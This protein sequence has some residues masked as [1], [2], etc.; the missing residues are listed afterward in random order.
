M[1]S[2]TAAHFRTMSEA[3]TRTKKVRA[4]ES[5]IDQA[6]QF[7]KRIR[8]AEIRVEHKISARESSTALPLSSHSVL[9]TVLPDTV[10]VSSSEAPATSSYGVL[11][12][13]DVTTPAAHHTTT[14]VF[15]TSTTTIT[16][17]TVTPVTHHAV[18]EPSN[19]K[20]KLPKLEPK[21]FNGDLTKWETFWNSFK[22]SIHS[23]PALTTIH[24]FQ[25]L[26]SLLKG[27]AF[28]DVAGLKLTELNY[29]EAIDTLTKRFGN[30]QLIIS[31]HM[32]TLLELEPVVSPTNIKV[33]RCLYDKI[34]FQ[35]HSLKSLGVPLDP[36]SNLLSSLFMSRL[37]QEF[38]LII[39]RE[40]VK[41]E[42]TVDQI[43]Q[44]VEREIG[45]REHAF[46]QTGSHAHGTSA[47]LPTATAMMGGDGKP[48]CC[49]CRQNHPSVSCKTVTD[50]AQ[51]IAIL[52]KSGR[53]FVCLKRHHL[54]RDCKSSISCY[55]CNGRH[56]A[57]VCK[58]HDSSSQS[59]GD[60]AN[61][62][63]Q[64]HTSNNFMIQPPVSSGHTTTTTA[65]F[66][67]INGDIPV[68]LQTVQAYIHKP[69][70]SA[71]GMT[72]RLMFDGGSQRLYIT[73]RVKEALR[74]ETECKEVVN[75]KNIWLRDFQ[76]SYCRCCHCFDTPQGGKSD[77]HFVLDCATNM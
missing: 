37:S 22:S 1:D 69:T 59:A 27:S 51:R 21:K 20:V 46:T 73:E 24:K 17:A 31:R 9:T 4:I 64:P 38:R 53:C 30:K 63:A 41:A 3:L 57:S 7:N 74:L 33:L 29:N 11:T 61:H 39:S 10:T 32:D 34:E 25:Y 26:I 70:D 6:D 40:I 67:C 5:K 68:L 60:S 12:T 52:K 42:W 44:I 15:D 43:M 19:S 71:C 23:N 48:K 65:G 2:T 54:S 18:T 36:Y 49:Y 55:F 8:Q 28:A 35:V 56:H 58:C 66:Y 77:K 72:I 76:N 62:S 16:S 13:L 50:V 45:A 14:A 47:G 75:I